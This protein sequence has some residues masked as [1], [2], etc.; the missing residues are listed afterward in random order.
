MNPS[1]QVIGTLQAAVDPVWS[2]C[3]DVDDDGTRRWGSVDSVE[4]PSLSPPPLHSRVGRPCGFTPQR[5]RGGARNRLPHFHT[6]FFYCYLFF[7]NQPKR[8]G[9]R[10]ALENALLHRTSAP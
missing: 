7:L 2:V 3:G 10:P 4:Q 6:P 8:R 5:F 1:H 9:P